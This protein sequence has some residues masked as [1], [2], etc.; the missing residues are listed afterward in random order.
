VTP[1]I[2]QSWAILLVVALGGLLS[3]RG[4]ILNIGLEGMITAGAFVAIAAARAGAVVPVAIVAGGGAAVM[5]AL[6]FALFSLRWNAN[7]FIVGLAVN[8]LAAGTVPL[9]SEILFGTRG[10]VRL[11]AGGIAVRSVVITAAAILLLVH[12][13]L[14][15]TPLGLRMRIAGEEPEWL[16]TRG[17]GVK[18]YQLAG[19]IGSGLLAGIAGGMLA[20]RVGVYLPNISSGRGWIA[21]VIVYLGYRTPAG[22][23]G[24]ALFFGIMEAIAVR[25]QAVLGVPPTILLALPYLLTVIAFV[26]YAAV[27]RSNALRRSG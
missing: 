26:S 19:L 6:L 7:P 11:E 4:G 18:R 23:A 10:S 16:R 24:A 13:V 9:L 15:H 3:E 2:L 1:Q 5:V 12:L 25:A 20:L 17:V 27:R 22:L 21:L 8:V 14:Y